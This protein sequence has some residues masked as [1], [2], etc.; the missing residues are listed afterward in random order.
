[1]NP[2]LEV[3]CS[4]GVLTQLDS[5][6]GVNLKL[7]NFSIIV[8]ILEADSTQAASLNFSPSLL[9]FSTNIVAAFLIKNMKT[10]ALGGRV[11]LFTV[12]TFSDISQKIEATFKKQI[13]N[14]QQQGRRSPSGG[15][16]FPH[17]TL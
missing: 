11:S 17:R 14:N 3:T 5:I 13:T 9:V 4:L 6:T 7:K 2:D 10:P 8:V 1:M 12:R 15:L 16:R